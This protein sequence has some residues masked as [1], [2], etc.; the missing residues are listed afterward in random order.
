MKYKTVTPEPSFLWITHR[1]WNV[2]RSRYW[3]INDSTNFSHPVFRLRDS[4]RFRF[5]SITFDLFTRE[6][7]YPGVGT[8][9]LVAYCWNVLSL[10]RPIRNS[11]FSL[12]DLHVTRS[13]FFRL[14]FE[15]S[16]T[17]IYQW[18]HHM[19]EYFSLT[20]RYSYNESLPQQAG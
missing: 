19:R 14:N 5:H 20:F 3:P 8:C 13:N 15:T 17:K 9:Q 11:S 6:N 18:F 12:S 16:S 7:R 1:T 4:F 2:W 10:K